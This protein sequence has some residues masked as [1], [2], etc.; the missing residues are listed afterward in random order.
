MTISTAQL[1][2][3]FGLVVSTVLTLLFLQPLL[4]GALFIFVER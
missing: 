3:G 4:M 1:I 2:S